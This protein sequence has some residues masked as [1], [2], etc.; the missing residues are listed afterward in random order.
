MFSMSS[1]L[2]M[3]RTH[4]RI[5]VARG[6]VGFSSPRKNGRNCVMPALV[7]S[8][9][10]GWCGMSPALGSGVW[11]WATKKSVHVRRNRSAFHSAMEGFRLPAKPLLLGG[12]DRHRDGAVLVPSEELGHHHRGPT[13]SE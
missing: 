8:G 6:W 3:I 4:F 2:P 5:V 13:S 12:D 9:A 1:C 10:R 7:N 11:S